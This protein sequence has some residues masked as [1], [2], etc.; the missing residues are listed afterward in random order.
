M[1]YL[2]REDVWCVETPMPL[3]VHGFVCRKSGQ[4]YMIIN[5]DL[6]DEAKK[7]AIR[8]ELDHID[9]GDLYSEEDA[10]VIEREKICT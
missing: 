4:I 2:I 1:E 9:G 5:S 3:T 7:E 10:V 8:H 6:S